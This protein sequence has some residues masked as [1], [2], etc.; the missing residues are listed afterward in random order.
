MRSHVLSSEAIVLS[1][2]SLYCFSVQQGPVRDRG[3]QISR[4]TGRLRLGRYPGHPDSLLQ[5]A[6]ADLRCLRQLR[7]KVGSVSILPVRCWFF[8]SVYYQAG[9]PSTSLMSRMS[10]IVFI[11]ISQRNLIKSYLDLT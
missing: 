2:T 10:M 11:F 8:S 3:V 7:P 4:Q 6:E 5:A 9:V 1:S